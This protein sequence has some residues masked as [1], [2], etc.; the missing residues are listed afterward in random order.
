M[1]LLLV[2]LSCSL[3]CSDSPENELPV[4]DSVRVT[5]TSS[6]E[7]SGIIRLGIFA[8][9]GAW[10]S[11]VPE[12]GTEV[13][14]QRSESFPLERVLKDLP[15]GSTIAVAAYHDV[16]NNGKLDRNL[17]GVP[18]EPYAFSGK[19]SSKWRAPRWEEV[20]ISTTARTPAIQ[21]DLRYWK[22]H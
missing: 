14:L 10:T 15:A 20:S 22:E 9:E 4:I 6:A 19:P 21:L 16:N 3:F 17:L 2:C 7:A 8:S 12:S 13:E 1:I 5:L 11:E 18:T